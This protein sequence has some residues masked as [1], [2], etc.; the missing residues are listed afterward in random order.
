[1][2][3]LVVVKQMD[4]IFHATKKRPHATKKRPHATKKRVDNFI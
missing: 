4:T 1:M 2:G 3:G